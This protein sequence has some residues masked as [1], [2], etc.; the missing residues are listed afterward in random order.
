MPAPPPADLARASLLLACLLALPGL[1][2][3]TA[4][5]PGVHPPAGAAPAARLLF[6]EPLDPNRAAAED[7]EVLPGIG[8]ARAAAIVA[9]RER[10]PFCGVGGLERVRGIGPSLRAGAEPWLRVHG[11]PCGSFEGSPRGP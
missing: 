1:W 5:A 2:P 11:A 9:E 10:G 4:P 7:L 6:G 8:P 3:A